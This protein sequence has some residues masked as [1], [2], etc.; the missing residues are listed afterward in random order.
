MT[1]GN[2][3]KPWRDEELLR[4]LYHEKRMS[5][6]EISD[7]FNGD[8]TPGG[9]GYVLDDLGIEKRSRSE[10][11]VVRW[12]GV[13]IKPYTDK[14]HSY[15]V[16]RSVR[17]G[18]HRVLHH[19]L[20]AVAKYGFDEVKGMV[21]HHKSGVEWDNRWSNIELMTPSE[22]AKHHHREDNIRGRPQ[23]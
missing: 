19:R 14:Y 23:K 9:I 10:A 12:E 16:I 2:K 5:Q 22:H 3:T 1:S 6:R 20:L 18:E 11:A 21:V 7:H 17:H 8:I 4:E 13:H 15:E